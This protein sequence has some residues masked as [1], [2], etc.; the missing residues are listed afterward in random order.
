MLLPAEV[1]SEMLERDD[2]FAGRQAMRLSFV[3][4]RGSYATLVLK[5]LA[6]A[7][8]DPSSGQQ[9][10]ASAG[11]SEETVSKGATEV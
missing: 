3:L 4:P 6:L 1:R 8:E 10:S 11:P 2:Q 7:E 5:R 9:P